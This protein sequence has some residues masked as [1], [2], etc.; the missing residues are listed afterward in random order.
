M[1]NNNGKKEPRATVRILSNLLNSH[2]FERFEEENRQE[3]VE[4][5]FC[6]CLMRMCQ[7]K[8]LTKSEMI[9]RSG[10]E[11]TYGYQIVRGLRNPTRDK[12]I[13]FAIGLGLDFDQTQNLLRAA[14]QGALYPRIKRDAAV[15]FA[16]AHNLSFADT[17]CLLAQIGEIPLD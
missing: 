8:G 9:S 15:I 7:S 12:V 2:D 5:D 17:Q 11:R 3:F 6:A 1:D 14:H 10:I 16:L 13:Q 4:E